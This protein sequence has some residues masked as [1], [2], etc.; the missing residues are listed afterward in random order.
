MRA[1]ASSYRRLK[2]KVSAIVEH[3]LNSNMNTDTAAVKPS[4]M[5]VFGHANP[6]PAHAS[7][8]FSACC[9]E[10]PS[11]KKWAP[12]VKPNFDI[13]FGG[14]AIPVGAKPGMA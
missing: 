12:G 9:A 10:A 3:L 8:S 4:K 2:K 7:V 6:A 11:S 1:A 13:T 5:I 14:E